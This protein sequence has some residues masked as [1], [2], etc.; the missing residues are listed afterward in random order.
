MPRYS[1]RF[2]RLLPI[3]WAVGIA[4]GCVLLAT[5]DR[6]AMAADQAPAKESPQRAAAE[7]AKAADRLNA[8]AKQFDA[9]NDQS[10]SAGEQAELVKFVTET[11]GPSWGGRL[12]PFLRGRHKPQ[13]LDRGRRMETGCPHARPGAKQDAGQGDAPNKRSWWPWVTA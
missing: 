4:A 10:L 1:G 6:D 11:F 13:P 9:D 3:A 8:L 5:A 7:L 12:E 2:R